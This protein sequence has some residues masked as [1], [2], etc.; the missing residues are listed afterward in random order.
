MYTIDYLK[1]L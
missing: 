1:F